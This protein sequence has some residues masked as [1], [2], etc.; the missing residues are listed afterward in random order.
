MYCLSSSTCII[1]GARLWAKLSSF[2]RSGILTVQ[3][4]RRF[5]G[6]ELLPAD[7]IK[8]VEPLSALNECL[9]KYSAY[10]P[11]KIPD[12][13]VVLENETL[14]LEL[15]PDF[16][17]N[18]NYWSQRNCATAKGSKVDFVSRFFGHN[19]GIDEDSDGSFILLWWHLTGL[20]NS[21]RNRTNS[22]ANISS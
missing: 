6:A 9:G 12:Y 18:G 8:E 17:S 22:L 2:S 10:F 16:K 19:R 4:Q 15:R 3:K 21:A 11:W 20:N 13:M 1:Y 14:V 5:I 7:E